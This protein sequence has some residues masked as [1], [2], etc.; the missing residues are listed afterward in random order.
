[1]GT[2][3]EEEGGEGKEPFCFVIRGLLT[4]FPR[5][6]PPLGDSLFFSSNIE[7]VH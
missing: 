4:F 7:I 2:T 3:K 5:N 1:M 6:F